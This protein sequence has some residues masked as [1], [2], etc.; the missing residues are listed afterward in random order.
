MAVV[1]PV[2]AFIIAIVVGLWCCQKQYMARAGDVSVDQKRE[3][4]K[5]L[6]AFD[7]DKSPE[8]SVGLRPAELFKFVL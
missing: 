3:A 7:R 1:A 6:F 2:V 8:P 4:E 5:R